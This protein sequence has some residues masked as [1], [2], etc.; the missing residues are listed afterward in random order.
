MGADG[1]VASLFPHTTALSEDRTLVVA[2][3]VPVL[4]RHRMTFTYPLINAA[5][6]VILLVTGDD[7]G[8]AVHELL[9]GGADPH[10]L[11]AAGVRPT[12]GT[13]SF[14]FDAAAARRAGLR[15]D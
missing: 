5:E 14:V 4:G 7:K 6:H 8:E 11:P 3:F 9:G 12:D 1:H 13:L 15:P 10:E 2:Q